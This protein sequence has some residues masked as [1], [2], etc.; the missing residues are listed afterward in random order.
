MADENLFQFVGPDL[1]RDFAFTR[2]PVRSQL[3]LTFAVHGRESHLLFVNPEPEH[4]LFDIM[5][6]EEVWIYED[7]PP[8]VPGRIKVEYWVDGFYQFS[9]DSVT[10]LGDHTYD[11]D[12]GSPLIGYETGPIEQD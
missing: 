7:E 2:L 1:V 12:P 9:A 4:E 5:K 11:T 8:G 6:A 3:T 10:D